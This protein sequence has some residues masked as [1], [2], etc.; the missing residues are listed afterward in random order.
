MSRV[1]P[2]LFVAG[3]LAEVLELTPVCT[4]PADEADNYPL[5]GILYAMTYQDLT[6]AGDCFDASSRCASPDEGSDACKMF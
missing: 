3:I 4:S 2:L 5:C 6:T 1:T